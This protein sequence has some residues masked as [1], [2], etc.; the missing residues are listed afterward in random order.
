LIGASLTLGRGDGRASEADE[1]D[2]AR[3]QLQV[4]IVDLAVSD[5]DVVQ[6]L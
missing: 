1:A 6:S 3:V 4:P 5:T 2:L